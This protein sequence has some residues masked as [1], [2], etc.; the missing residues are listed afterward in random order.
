MIHTVRETIMVSD[1]SARIED[2]PHDWNGMESRE[3]IFLILTWKCDKLQPDI[4]LVVLR[5]CIFYFATCDTL[6]HDDGSLFLMAFQV[7]LFLIPR[8][9]A[10]ECI[11]KVPVA[12]NSAPRPPIV[13]ILTGL[14]YRERN[15]TFSNRFLISSFHIQQY[16]FF[17]MIKFDCHQ[18]HSIFIYDFLVAF[19][20]VRTNQV[21]NSIYNPNSFKRIIPWNPIPGFIDDSSYGCFLFF[22]IQTRFL[23][24]MSV[25]VEWSQTK[26]SSSSSNSS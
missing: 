26:N 23:V 7:N 1:L 15:Q 16:N 24:S 13:V 4:L 18:H 20:S 25:Y 8:M 19:S 17:V 10:E 12:Y 6:H 3:N 5:N 21:I 11:Q 22:S 14:R 2:W 9:K